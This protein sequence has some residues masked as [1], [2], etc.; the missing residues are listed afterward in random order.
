MVKQPRA[1]QVKTRLA[2][3]TGTVAATRFYRTASAAVIGR[4]AASPRW[5]TWLA[6]A[7]DTAVRA[8]AWP[9]RL[10]RR[11]QRG[12]GLGQRMQR[13]MGWSGGGPMVIVG[14]DIPAIRTGDI[15]AAFRAL[16]AAD[17][18]LGPAEDGG[19]WLVGLR[20][21]P[22]TL[23]PFAD[24][25]WSSEHALADTVRN[26]GGRRVAMVECHSDVDCAADLARVAAWCGRRVLPV[27]ASSGPVAASRRTCHSGES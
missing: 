27:A 10:P 15:A 12:G 14:T 20:R 24:V 9:A 7:P 25:R 17:A 13:I 1:G 19:Y 18:A 21:S 5:Q 11:A 16:G 4:L 6:V 23:R 8:S 26:L 3:Q 22:R 2:R